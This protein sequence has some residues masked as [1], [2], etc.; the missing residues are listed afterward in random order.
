[1]HSLYAEAP[2]S[3]I[4]IG[5]CLRPPRREPAWVRYEWLSWKCKEVACQ[6]ARHA[7]LSMHSKAKFWAKVHWCVFLLQKLRRSETSSNVDPAWAKV[8]ST[9]L[10]MASFQI[11]TIWDEMLEP[12]RLCFPDDR[13]PWP[14]FEASL[15]DDARDGLVGEKSSH[16]LLWDWDRWE[17]MRRYITYQ[18]S[19][20]MMRNFWGNSCGGGEEWLNTKVITQNA[21]S[22]RRQNTNL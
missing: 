1:M 11:A 15:I 2:R 13:N 19:T 18:R 12:S 9:Q 17:E 16:L 4:D 3:Q 6:A 8:G 20:F 5:R 14:W 21:P 7:A 22:V 10:P